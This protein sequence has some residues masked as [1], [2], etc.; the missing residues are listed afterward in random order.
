M[1]ESSP[2]PLTP[3]PSCAATTVEA[4]SQSSETTYVDYLRCRTCGHVWTV[5]KGSD[6]VFRHITP[7]ARRRP[8][9]ES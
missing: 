1:N 5:E 4:L 3:C 6:V 7:L 8:P 2:R 9:G